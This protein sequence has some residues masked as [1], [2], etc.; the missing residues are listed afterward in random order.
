MADARVGRPRV[1]RVFAVGLISIFVCRPERLRARL[2]LSE[3][4]PEPSRVVD[5]GPSVGW[6]YYRSYR[7]GSPT[8]IQSDRAPQ[9]DWMAAVRVAPEPEVHRRLGVFAGDRIRRLKQLEGSSEVRSGWKVVLDAA[10]IGVEHSVICAARPS[11]RPGRARRWV[12][13]PIRRADIC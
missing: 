9:L 5:S 10:R 3:E 12:V 1:F 6:A 11:Y 8:R 4:F 2:G 7:R 13:D